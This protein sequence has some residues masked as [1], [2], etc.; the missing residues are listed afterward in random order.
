MRGVLH[1]HRHSDEKRNQSRP[2]PEPTAPE[3]GRT[4]GNKARHGRRR[5]GNKL[6]KTTGHALRPVQQIDC[7]QIILLPALTF[8]VKSKI[9]G[10]RIEI[11][12]GEIGGWPALNGQRLS[13]RD[14]GVK[15][16]RDFLRDLALDCEQV[17]LNRD[18]IAPPK[19]GCLCAYRS[20]GHLVRTL[21]LERRTFLPVREKRAVRSDLAQVTVCRD[22]P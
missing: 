10:A 21:P 8:H 9:L 3:Y 17:D 5:A 2:S 13:G 4:H 22:T 6:G 11:E 7:L 15:S 12:R 19:H 18:R 20:T 16:L 1:Q 14:F